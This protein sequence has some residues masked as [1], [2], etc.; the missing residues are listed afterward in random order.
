M[1]KL[2]VVLFVAFS[3]V[4]KGQENY[5]T[6]HPVSQFT[7]PTPHGTISVAAAPRFAANPK[8]IILLIGDGMGVAQLYGGFTANKGRLNIFNMPVTG[9][10]QTYSNSDYVTDSGAGGTAIATGVKTNNG[11]IGVDASD[12]AVK[13]ILHLAEEKGLATGLVSTSAITHATPAAFIAHVPNRS[14]YEDIALDFLK[15]D[16]DVFIGGG[17]KHFDE[18]ADGRKLSRELEQK[19]YR[20]AFS[21]D[22]AGDGAKRL[23]V[24]T[25]D[26]H[27][28][29]FS[30]RGDLLPR[31]TQKALDLL[32]RNKK[33]FFLMVEGSQIDWGGHQND[34]AYVVGETLDF[35]LAVGKALEYALKDKRTLVIVA[36]DHETG[37]L[38]LVGGSIANGEVK[39]AFGASNHTATMV[40]VFAF[41][42]GA[43]AFAGVYQNTDLFWKMVDLLG[44]SPVS[45]KSRPT[46]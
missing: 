6:N 19:G 29:K 30:E 22:E 3:L 9:F 7:N 45:K 16:I 38:S 39:A 5:K 11:S 25:A 37:G 35:D 20:V 44:V 23:A 28:A 17:R 26:E 27:N 14:S 21:L 4:A 46:R 1:N 42:A 33:G 10:T 8:K 13:S 24:L 40:P 15:T 2:F 31:A 12:K 32:S 41:G 43:S 34:V 18:R 36:A